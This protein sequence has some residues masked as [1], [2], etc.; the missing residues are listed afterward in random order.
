M[1]N[2][3]RGFGRVS[4]TVPAVGGSYAPEILYL[5]PDSLAEPTSKGGFDPIDVLSVLLEGTPPASA[6]VEVDLLVGSDPSVAGDWVVNAATATLAGLHDQLP[7]S[8]WRGVRL[9][10]KSGGTGGT[11]GVS[12]SWLG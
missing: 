8:G 10:C 5:A 6:Q 12:A 2:Q 9:R 11:L 3:V 7:L 4:F 1:F